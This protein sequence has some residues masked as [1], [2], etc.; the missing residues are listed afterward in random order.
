MSAPGRGII[1]DAHG[2]A[3][4]PR[5]STLSTFKPGQFGRF[6]EVEDFHCFK[7]QDH[8]AHDKYDKPG[9]TPPNPRDLTTFDEIVGARDAIDIASQLIQ[10]WKTSTPWDAPA[11][12]KELLIETVFKL[13]VAVTNSDSSV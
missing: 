11:G 6:G 2:A 1:P 5:Q 13:S 3:V 4:M 10:L 8:D 7:Y 12:A 9:P